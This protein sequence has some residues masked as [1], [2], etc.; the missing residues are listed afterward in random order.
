VPRV[1][2]VPHAISRL[3]PICVR[4]ASVDAP[5]RVSVGIASSF[6]LPFA[7]GRA[8]FPLCAACA[9]TVAVKRAAERAATFLLALV[10]LALVGLRFRPLLVPALVILAFLPSAFARRFERQAIGITA[11]KQLFDDRLALDVTNADV[12]ARWRRR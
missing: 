11:K 12:V 10:V 6:P 9:R 8:S 1:V 5:K 4:C 3:E 7:L 2:V